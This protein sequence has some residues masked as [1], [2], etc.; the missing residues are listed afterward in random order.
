MSEVM[1]SP[2]VAEA[3]LVLTLDVGSSSVR[4]MLF[5][6]LGRAVKGI[7]VREKYRL[8]TPESGAAEIE[9]DVLLERAFGCLDGLLD[10]AGRLAGQ[11]GGVGISTLVSNLLGV[12]GHGRTTTP[13]Y[14]YADTRA[15]SDAAFLRSQL[16][17]PDVHNRT[18][19]RLHT[20]YLP[21]RFLWLART[22]PVAFRRTKHWITIGEYI[23]QRLFGHTKVSYSVA[24]WSGLLDRSRLAWDEPL[25]EFLPI[26]KEQLSTL[27]DADQPLIGLREE[28]AHRWPL[29][30][31]IPW[32][33]AIGDGAASN[34]GIGCVSSRR[35]AL[36][37][38]TSA[39]LRVM[40][41]ARIDELPSSLWCYRLDRQQS[42]LGGAL[43]E[44]GNV[45]DWMTDILDVGKKS[46]LHAALCAMEPDSHNLT[47]LPFLAGERSPGWAGHARGAIQGLSLNTRPVDI[48]RAG[49]EA[50]A[51]RLALV[52]DDILGFVP[53]LEQVVAS[54]GAIS[55]L[56]AWLQIIAD[57]L[58]QPIAASGITEASS[59]GVAILVLEAISE[60]PQACDTP[61]DV[62]V[63][64]QPDDS[65][66]QRYRSALVRQQALYESL[67]N[68][69]SD[70]PF[71]Q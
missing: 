19:C 63:V 65:R 47:V 40:M 23:F 41:K 68:H 12:D 15:E 10:R 43:T 20:S 52:Y 29:L 21:A 60:F 37:L 44:G 1:I 70:G 22:R 18:G 33:P 26:S 25:L 61:D 38:G 62:D 34:I 35:I 67:I 2:R 17:E 51:L 28:F 55:R 3:P 45:L 7:Q 4:S 42:L 69:K 49:L 66:H 64:Y 9:P 36:S 58:G 8:E 30:R 59:R 46:Q 54:G 53:S 56:P 24:S 48:L 16:N 71:N 11:I 14:T 13:V 57:A 5:D 32:F 27:T 39:A 50:V 31:D 6:R